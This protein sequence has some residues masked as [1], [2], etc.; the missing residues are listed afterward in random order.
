VVRLTAE[1]AG[2]TVTNG[3]TCQG[4]SLHVRVQGI[5]LQCW[6]EGSL[7]LEESIVIEPPV[8]AMTLCLTNNWT[9][10][11]KS[12]VGQWVGDLHAKVGEEAVHPGGGFSNMGL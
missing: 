6:V 9:C 12:V 11:G 8:P 1:C 7:S 10:I 4:F 3:A 2:R 5:P